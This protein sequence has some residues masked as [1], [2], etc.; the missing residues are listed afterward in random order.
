M[1]EAPHSTTLTAGG[2]QIGQ[3][4]PAT[5]ERISHNNILRISCI[6]WFNSTFNIMCR[7]AQA[8]RDVGGHIPHGTQC[9]MSR[10]ACELV[11]VW[12][13]KMG[14]SRREDKNPG[15]TYFQIG[16]MNCT[17]ARIYLHLQ[18]VTFGRCYSRTKQC[19]MHPSLKIIDLK[20]YVSFTR[21]LLCSPTR[22]CKI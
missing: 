1:G 3:W 18:Q 4:K 13:Q 6:C 20:D 8:S 10:C 11:R 12:P 5:D 21:S 19:I 16:W 2:F 14:L 22:Q 17:V 9:S 7:G 15:L